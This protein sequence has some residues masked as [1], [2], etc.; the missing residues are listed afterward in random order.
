V[1]R[2]KEV[3]DLRDLLAQ[4]ASKNAASFAE[5]NIVHTENDEQNDRI[6]EEFRVCGLSVCRIKYT[7]L[8]YKANRPYATS[9]LAKRNKQKM[10][11]L[12]VPSPSLELV[13]WYMAKELH[14]KD[15]K[16]KGRTTNKWSNLRANAQER[17]WLNRDHREDDIAEL[18][19][20]SSD[21]NFLA[22]LAD[23]N[24]NVKG[25]LTD[26]FQHFECLKAAVADESICRPVLGKDIVHIMDKN[27]KIIPFLCAD[28]LQKKF[29]AG[30]V[31]KMKETFD[32]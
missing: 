17:L 1:L 16:G 9:A 2:T 22:T 19:K 30:S 28:A 24:K 23:V 25:V 14:T 32:R 12:V 5:E 31:D 27:N 26:Q 7:K 21:S 10:D 13:Q 6:F 8:D 3:R 29:P 15:G 18:M 20:G 4:L 11:D